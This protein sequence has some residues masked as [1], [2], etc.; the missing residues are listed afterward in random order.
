MDKTPKFHS[1]RCFCP[2][3]KTGEK[4]HIGK[5]LR[6]P[7]AEIRNKYPNLPATVKICTSCRKTIRLQGRA[8]SISDPVDVNHTDD[9]S[10]FNTSEEPET[11][12]E[13]CREKE[14]EEFFNGIKEHFNS[15]QDNYERIRILTMAPLSWNINKVAIEFGCSWRMANN[16]RNLRETR[17]MLASPVL[18]AGKRFPDNT[19]K[20]IEDF[21]N[22]DEN[23]RVMDGKK[24]T[25]TVVVDG[26]KVKKQK[27]LLLFNLKE[28]YANWKHSIV[29]CPVSFNKFATLRPSNCILAGASG[30]HSVCVCTIHQNC[31]LM[32]DAINISQLTKT[33]KNPLNNYKDCLKL[34]MCDNPSLA[35]YFNECP[36]CPGEQDFVDIL[37]ELLNEKLITSVFFSIWQTTDRA[38][39]RTEKL[40]VE[41]FLTELYSK[42]KQ[43]KPHDF[44]AKE[45]A[46][47]MT[48]QKDTLRDG[49]ILIQLD[50][51]ENYAFVV[52]DAAQAFHFNNDQC[53]LHTIVYYYRS[54]NQIRHRSMVV[55]SDC[56]SHD[57]VAV[58]I[59][60][61]M[62]LK[63]ITKKCAV[64]KVIYFTDGAK[65]HFKNRFQISNLLHHEED[66]GISA[67][68][69]F[70]ATAHGKGGCDGVGAAFKRE[71][72]RASLQAP[73]SR[74]ILTPKRLF[75]WAQNRFE[76]IDIFFYSAEKHTKV[77]VQ[78]KKRFNTAQAIP[79]IQKSHG[80]IPLDERKLMIKTFSACPEGVIFSK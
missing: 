47:F 25:I 19:A 21:Y 12:G 75:E 77:T 33:L 72:T 46:K 18:K 52:Q 16:A 74:A 30:T 48:L 22:S 67:E 14:L 3:R 32:L 70:H 56:L 27:R 2:F 28:L 53:T 23:S 59:I 71:A 6:N 54:G 20:K 44:I 43:L 79:N 8:E 13:K 80:F 41:D 17:G 63:E 38:T 73:A 78:L 36:S 15:L 69:H 49:E 26:E 1:R 11:S 57:T 42:L 24:D 45:Q 65:Q 58:H 61:E 9:G 35:C 39:L 7:S 68:W 50:F 62:I 51:A 31:K 66:F 29:D 55:L 4:G 40:S 37:R 76:N 5:S 64:K 60:Q 34:L 10:N